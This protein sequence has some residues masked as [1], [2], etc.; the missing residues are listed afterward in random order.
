[1]GTGLKRRLRRLAFALLVVFS[2]TTAPVAVES[3]QTGV[4]ASQ[5]RTVHAKDDGGGKKDH[6]GEKKGGG[7]GGGDGSGI[8]K[9]GGDGGSY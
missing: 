3:N 8:T 4:Y 9:S 6:G 1:M 7:N 5:P 2:L